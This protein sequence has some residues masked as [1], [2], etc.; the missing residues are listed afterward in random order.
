MAPLSEG[1]V[2]S[3]FSDEKLKSGASS[4]PPNCGSPAPAPPKGSSTTRLT[5]C[6]NQS[7]KR[8]FLV[9]LVCEFIFYLNQSASVKNSIEVQ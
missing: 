7:F 5:C 8:Y 1:Q 6:R 2:Q 3:N 9:Y 4:L